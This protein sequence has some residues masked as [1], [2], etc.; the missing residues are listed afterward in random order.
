ME[1]FKN[2]FVLHAAAMCGR[3]GEA[4]W[5]QVERAGELSYVVGCLGSLRALCEDEEEEG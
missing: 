2:L 3:G 4:E 1:H 5:E